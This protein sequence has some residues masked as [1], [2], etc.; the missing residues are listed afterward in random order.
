MCVPG[1]EVGD[2][3]GYGS[4]GAVWSGIEIRSGKPVALKRLPVVSAA[5]LHS[6]RAE[7]AL[8]AVLD[9]PSLIRFHQFVV[10]SD[11]VFLVQELADGGSL[12]D[13]L[14]RRDRLTVPEVAAA[15]SPV[16]AALAHVHHEGIIHGDISAA[17]VLFTRTGHPKL[18][19]LGVARMFGDE[20]SATG[21]PRYLDPVVA[22]GGAAGA[23]SDVF[24]IAAVAL[25][26]LTGRGPWQSP[27]SD[28]SS[29][30]ID[31]VLAKA[32]TGVIE[33]LA[34][35]LDGLPSE[36][37]VTLV[38]ALDRDPHRR[39]A[40]ADFALDLRAATYEAPVVLSA[41]RLATPAATHVG[42]HAAD[43]AS[44]GGKHPAASCSPDR[45][46]SASSD[47]YPA[48]ENRGRASE[49]RGRPYFVR[50]Y[51][52]ESVPADLTHVARLRVREP[53]KDAPETFQQRIAAFA[54]RRRRAGV[55]TV[56]LLVLAT[57][58][59][60]A[61]WEARSSHPHRATD[62]ADVRGASVVPA[63]I[64]Q[65]IDKVRAEAFAQRRAD[66]LRRVYASPDLLAQDVERL[67]AAV[68]AGC[69][70]IGLTTTYTAISVTTQT[71]GRIELQASASLP[72]ARLQ[73]GDQVGRPS[74]SAG[75][76]LM[77]IVLTAS[78]PGGFEIA[79]QRIIA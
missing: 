33:D 56:S 1:Y 12:A 58:T 24:S 49:N 76:T 62:V 44:R 67:Q 75:P 61:A 26:A 2:L 13:L 52:T 41:G 8:L 47:T 4:H 11:A 65:A 28:L 60:I 16:A 25:H 5:A 51:V 79:S 17:N 34:G 23:A 19:D 15:L 72:P 59:V 57:I 22:A 37:A 73:C 48:S 74:A 43:R 78:A 64:L 29:D 30:D 32:A 68:P 55:V 42:K 71:T 6:A 36:V 10:V 53:A 63:A 70:L 7:A 18:A 40:A 3:V 14:Q 31:D 66:L 27:S 50:P 38:R 45:E 69:G 21:T 35:R 54:R 46:S 39:G 20:S 77:R 9:H